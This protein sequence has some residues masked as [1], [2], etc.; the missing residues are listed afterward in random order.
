[1]IKFLKLFKTQWA[2]V[3]SA[4]RAHMMNILGGRGNMCVAVTF[5]P[6]FV[7]WIPIS[8]TCFFKLSVVPLKSMQ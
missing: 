5:T 7:T 6:F 2:H 8:A 1:M 4:S 3:D